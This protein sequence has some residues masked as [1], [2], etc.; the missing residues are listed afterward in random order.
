MLMPW[1]IIMVVAITIM[2]KSEVFNGIGLLIH[3][4]TMMPVIIIIKVC[5]KYNP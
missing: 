3:E 1:V 4:S 5:P 2:V